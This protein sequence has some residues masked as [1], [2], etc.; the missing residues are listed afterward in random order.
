[1]GESSSGTERCETEAKTQTHQPIAIVERDPDIDPVRGGGVNGA[2]RL[3]VQ[4][5]IHGESGR[6][7][8]SRDDAEKGGKEESAAVGKESEKGGEAGSD[9]G[10]QD[11]DAGAVGVE[12][13][14]WR[15]P[16]KCR[17]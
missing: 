10:S 3:R 15:R 17:Q 12:I 8:Q 7:R 9:R 6:E 4:D 2:V 14:S 16:R 13:E 1:M 5:L 11:D